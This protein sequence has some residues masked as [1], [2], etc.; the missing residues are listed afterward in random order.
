MKI[1]QSINAEVVSLAEAKAE[2][3]VVF[4]GRKPVMSYVLAVTTVLSASKEVIIK[5]RG[6][7]ISR[8]VDTAEIVRNRFMPEV[9]IKDITIDT[10]EVKRDD[11]TTMNVSSM[12][13]TLRK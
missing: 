9:K 1:R 4:V 12:E 7:A 3:N 13:I 6:Q 8:A 5:S 2:D 10:E 11:G